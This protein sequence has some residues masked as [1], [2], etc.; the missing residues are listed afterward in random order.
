MRGLASRSSGRRRRSPTD[1]RTALWRSCAACRSAWTP[2]RCALLFCLSTAYCQCPVGPQ[3]NAGLGA[4]T[5]HLISLNSHSGSGSNIMMTCKCVQADLARER[6]DKAAVKEASAKAVT[7][8]KQHA[9]DMS[10]DL[11][12]VHDNLEVSIL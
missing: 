11:E 6:E 4:C 1:R 2:S 5:G 7:A 10:H 9:A 12:A 8:A 3:C